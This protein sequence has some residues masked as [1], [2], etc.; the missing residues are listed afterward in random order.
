MQ[1]AEDLLQESL[2][3]ALKNVESYRGEI[4]EK[5]W[6]YFILKNKL[7]DYYRKRSRSL[8]AEIPSLIENEHDEFFDDVGHWKKEAYPQEFSLSFE[9]S[10]ESE[11]KNWIEKC[12]ERLSELQGMVFSLKY[13]DDK[14][15]QEICKE[16]GITSSNYWVI[17]HRAKLNLRK[18][19]E[20]AQKKF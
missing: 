10:A 9:S 1:D 4:S 16:L 6:L 15:S 5:N 13:I 20:K 2:L 3:S 19:L 11:L 14:D 18:C 17:I 7:I 12:L 8:M